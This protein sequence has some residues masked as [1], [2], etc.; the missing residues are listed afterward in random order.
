[1][2]TIL[3]SVVLGQKKA[4]FDSFCEVKE[5]LLTYVEIEEFSII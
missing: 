2:E 4:S 5:V 3:C 1:M